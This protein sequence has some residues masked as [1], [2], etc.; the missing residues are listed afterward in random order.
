M[1]LIGLLGTIAMFL[2]GGGIIAHG[3]PGLEDA[4]HHLVASISTDETVGAILQ[5][6]AVAIIGIATGFVVILLVKLLG[7]VLGPP[8][9]KLKAR[10]AARRKQA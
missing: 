4:A 9:R 10:W 5:Q 3:I 2:V 1:K 6:L 7:P 8:L